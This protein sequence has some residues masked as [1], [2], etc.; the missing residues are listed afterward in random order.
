MLTEGK[1][2]M[3]LLFGGAIKDEKGQGERT[4][5]TKDG[6]K[7]ISECTFEVPESSLHP[8]SSVALSSTFLSHVSLFVLNFLCDSLVLFLQGR[9]VTFPHCYTHFHWGLL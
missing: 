6:R 2:K 5:E 8:F 1:R 9:F 3:T 7:W 4:K